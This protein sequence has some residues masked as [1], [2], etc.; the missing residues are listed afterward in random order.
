MD[1]VDFTAAQNFETIRF[2]KSI[3]SRLQKQQL[4]PEISKKIISKFSEA[5]FIC[6]KFE[7]TPPFFSIVFAVPSSVHLKPTL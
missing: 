6:Q 5:Q 2:E 1:T 7:T 3:D 4:L